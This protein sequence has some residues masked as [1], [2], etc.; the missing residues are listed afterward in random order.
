MLSNI[1]RKCWKRKNHRVFS[2]ACCNPNQTYINPI[3]VFH[4]PHQI[5]KSCLQSCTIFST[6]Q[7]FFDYRVVGCPSTK[8]KF[9]IFTKIEKLPTYYFCTRY[10][11]FWMLTIKFVEKNRKM[12]YSSR[13]TKAKDQLTTPSLARKSKQA[14]NNKVDFSLMLDIKT[15]RTNIDIWNRCSSYTL[16]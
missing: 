5:L 13:S 2:C 16:W 9:K 3:T 6:I 4:Q 11:C 14:F 8:T 1:L 10:A 12:I 15:Y 7:T